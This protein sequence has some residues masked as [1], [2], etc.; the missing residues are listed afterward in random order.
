[1]NETR[2]PSPW[3]VSK[4]IDSEH[5]H[6]VHI[7]R[8]GDSQIHVVGPEREQITN[9]IA[10]A[11]DMLAML[12]AMIEEENADRGVHFFGMR[13]SGYVAIKKLIARAKGEEEEE[14]EI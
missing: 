14:E 9:L 13:G 3:I 4:I 8:A 11:P 2:V 7:I 5:M 1:M 6:G 10:A 12:E